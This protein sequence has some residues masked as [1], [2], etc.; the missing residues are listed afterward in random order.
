LQQSS[1]N[2]DFSAVSSLTENFPLFTENG[3]TFFANISIYFE[4]RIKSLNKYL[5]TGEN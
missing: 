2:T 3:I 4:T 5:L 1:F